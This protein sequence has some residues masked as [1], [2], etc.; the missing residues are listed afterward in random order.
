M[1][2]TIEFRN[3]IKSSMDEVDSDPV[4]L[5]SLLNFQDFYV[6]KFIYFQISIFVFILTVFGHFQVFLMQNY[7]VS[8]F[9]GF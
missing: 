4:S 6:G 1:D 7:E 5:T 3:S 9:Q 8:E 2:A